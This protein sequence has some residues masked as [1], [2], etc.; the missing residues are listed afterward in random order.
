L[1]IAISDVGGATAVATSTASVA[2]ADSLAA[3][4][5]ST[6]QSSEGATFSGSVATFSDQFT[7][8]TSN[9]FTAVI[10][11]GDGTTWTGTVSGSG[12]NYTISGSHVFSEEGTYVGSSTLTDGEQGSS[13]S[14]T[15][16]AII[17]DPAVAAT[18]GLT[19]TAVEGAL[20]ADQ[21]V[22][23]F[24][25]PA[26]AEAATNYSATIEWG[27]GSTSPGTI[28]LDTASS[29]FTVLGTHRY[30]ANGNDT[31]SV[32]ITHDQSTA[33]TVSSTAAVSDPAVISSGGYTVSGEEATDSGLQ[34]IATFT[35]PGSDLPPVNY[36]ATID[37]GDSST[38]TGTVAGPD[39]DSVYTVS[40]RHFYAEEGAYSIGVSVAHGGAPV[41]I[42][43]SNASIADVAVNAIAG[44]TFPATEG[45]ASLVE[46]LATFTDPAGAEPLVNYSASIAWGDGA[47]T[48]GVITFDAASKIFTICAAHL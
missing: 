42:S 23:T 31:V 13:A 7:A 9:D 18:G 29:S 22:A 46:S 10:V 38:S 21:T 27:D 33:V 41:G 25:D 3:T 4:N 2:D 34:T 16:T 45:V 35:D 8:N 32:I 12:S 26:G 1:K 36:T 6:I 15:F 5:Q 30:P 39:V 20:A 28:S 37:W 43:T 17:S 40:G 44:A 11:W 14:A 47:T 19:F 48:A 24:D